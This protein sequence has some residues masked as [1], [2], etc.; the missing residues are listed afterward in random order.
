[1][2]APNFQ[3]LHWLLDIIQSTDIGIVVIDK[4]F[5]IEIYNRFMQVHSN[6]GPEDAIETSIFDLFP[7]LEDEWF[8]RRVNTV[9]ELGISVYTTW[10]QRDNVFDFALKL[11]IHYETQMMYQNTTFIPLRSASDQ[12]EKVGIVVYD[13][14]DNAVNRG[15]LETAK[16]ELLRLSRTDK[17]TALW[18]RGYWEERMIDEFKRNQRSDKQTSL[19]IF[20]IDHFKNI[21]D[22]YGHQVGDDAIRTV[23]K[24]FLDNSRDVDICG[25]YGGEEFVVLLPETDVEGAKIYCERLRK[26]I[27]ETT[28]H[29]QGESV[30]FTIS[31]GIA[32]LDEHTK[33]PTDWMVNA[34]KALYKSKESGRNQ[35]NVFGD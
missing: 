33:F 23:S 1:M 15:K 3:D 34:D 22:T 6:I 7:Y 4:N 35:T 31:L 17:L 24:L 32:V 25:R 13:V 20:D 19:V 27:A 26:A 8:K 18:N 10:E 21:N 16:D 9:F 28:V 29:S 11:P 12:V 30:N 5:N 2:E 14:T